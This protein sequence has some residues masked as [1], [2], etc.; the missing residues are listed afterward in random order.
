MLGM[1][2]HQKPLRRL[3]VVLLIVMLSWGITSCSQSPDGTKTSLINKLARGKLTEVSPP[4]A[5]QSL[6]PSLEIYQPQVKILAPRANQTLESSQVQVQVQ[7]NDLPLF[8]DEDLELGPYLQVLLDNQPYTQ[9]YDVSEPLTID[10]LTPGTHT[11]RVFAVRPW[12]ESFKNEGA[13]AQA[14][15][16]VFTRTPENN[17]KPNQPLL[18]YNAPQG[19]YGAEPVLLD[20]Y[21]T[22]APLH[23]VAR[24]D[25]QDAIPD[26]TIRCTINGESFN[27]DRW[28]PIYLKGLKPGQNWVQLEL[29]DE[30]GTPIPNV[31]NNAVQ[32]VTYNPGGT[33]T[34]SLLSRGELTADAARKIVDPNYVPPPPLPEPTFEPTPEPEVILEPDLNQKPSPEVLPPDI[35]EPSSQ[36]S[37]LGEPSIESD[38][39]S[40]I[41]PGVQPTIKPATAPASEPNSQPEST[42]KSSQPDLEELIEAETQI[43]EQEKPT[44]APD[45]AP[46]VVPG[47]QPSE[48]KIVAPKPNAVPDTTPLS[49]SALPE[50]IDR[51]IAPTKLTIPPVAPVIPEPDPVIQEQL[52]IVKDNVE[53]LLQTSEELKSSP[54]STQPKRF[55]PA[56]AYDVEPLPAIEPIGLPKFPLLESPTI[57]PT[58]EQPVIEP[59]AIKAEPQAL[60]IIPPATADPVGLPEARPNAPAT[61]SPTSKFLGALDRVKGFFEDLRKRPTEIKIPLFSPLEEQNSSPIPAE[62][63][64]V[65]PDADPQSSTSI[66]EG[67]QT[68]S[69]EEL[70]TGSPAP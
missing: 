62:P 27:F 15:F 8:K 30:T 4:F 39:Q 13:F 32:I 20:F 43:E 41:D 5:I 52:G 1:N 38:T 60:P 24:E 55:K 63:D 10:N 17:P 37:P 14:T 9:L 29:L 64:Q 3:L 2:W 54:L 42:L 12:H 6:K 31:F 16:H 59:P 69:I 50:S 48:P 49:E 58:I 56:K 44:V 47:P 36:Q 40:T 34:L 68:Q 35:V 46:D 21:L 66:P 25:S 67:L 51:P 7:V 45:V 61:P 23:L 65:K 28:E 33:D 53:E 70:L 57:E 22:N 18:T 11:L 19:L 26:W